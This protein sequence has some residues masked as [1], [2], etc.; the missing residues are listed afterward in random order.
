[1]RRTEE[2]LPYVDNWAVCDSFAPKCFAK[3]K[4]ELIPKI[5]E[6]HRSGHTY[7][8]R[9][10]TG[11]LMRWYL[12][13][14]FRTEDAD[15]AASVRSSEY[16]VNMMTAWYFATALAKQYDAVLPYITERRLDPW[17]HNKAIQKAIESFRVSDEHKQYLRTLKIKYL[18]VGCDLLLREA[19]KV[20]CQAFFQKSL[21]PEAPE[22]KK[23]P[24]TG[25][26]DGSVFVLMKLTFSS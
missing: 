19:F 4:Q 5:I 2:F 6:W 13:G 20:F 23:P 25:V 21:P 9:F 3:H 24:A 17:T 7:K 22:R 11:C 26:T 14:D 10:G 18:S 8:I 1:M 16:Y 12:D 15:M